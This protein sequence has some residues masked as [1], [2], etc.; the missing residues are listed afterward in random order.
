MNTFAKSILNYFATYTE[1]RFRFQSKSLYKWT[2]NQLTSDFPVFPEFQKKLLD[3][4]KAKKQIDIAVHKSEYTVVLDCDEFKNRLLNKLNGEYDLGYLI[5]CIGESR[6]DFDDTQPS[7]DAQEIK[8]LEGKILHSAF[9]KYNLAYRSAIRD[10]LLELQEEKK[11]ELVHYIKDS[12]IPLTSFNPN[13]I[14]Q[15]I[16]ESFREQASKSKDKETFHAKL[17]EIIK[18]S[19]WNLEMYDLYSMIRK[20]AAMLNK[21]MGTAYIFF[22]E[23]Y[24][25]QNE[26]IEQFPLFLIEIDIEEY[27]ESVHIKS[28][29]GVVLINTPAI[30]SFYFDTILTIPRAARLVEATDYLFGVEKFLQNSYDFYNTFLLEQG[31]DSL[32]AEKRPKIS[33][34]VGFQIVL[35]EDR[36]LLDYSE[37]ITRI[38]AGQG[39][40]FID[41]VKD[42]VSGNVHNTTDEVDK[43]YKERY[44]PK[45]AAA[46]LST[47]PLSLNKTQKRILTALANPKNRIIVIDGPP[48]T[49]KSYTIAAM[50]YWANQNEK[51]VVITS[52]KKAAIDVLDRMMTDYF[53]KL[54][55]RAKPSIMRIS[56]D[57]SQ[58]VNNYQNTLASQV[59]SAS[60]SRVNEFNEDAIE[61]DVGNWREKV[62]D[63]TEQYWGNAKDYPQGIS[64]LLKLE[65]SEQC[66][67][68]KG[69]LTD[70][71]RPVKITDSR[72]SLSDIEKL[73]KQLPDD[74]Q[75]ITIEKLFSLVTNNKDSLDRLLQA[76]NIVNS[77]PLSIPQVNKL[78]KISLSTIVSFSK[79]LSQL[80]LCLKADS[81]IFSASF[82]FKLIARIKYSKKCRE[83]T[84]KIKQLDTLE[85]H[86]LLENI[87][88]INAKDKKDLL[89][90]DF[91]NGISI[92][93]EI[94]GAREYIEEFIQLRITLEFENK[95]IRDIFD[96]LKSVNNLIKNMTPAL[97]G[98]LAVFSDIFGGLL[99][100][101]K[102][103]AN[104]L[105]DLKVL[106]DGKDMYKEL[107]EYIHLF[108]KL[109]QIE[110][111]VLPDRQLVE[112]Y[113]EALHKQLENK[114]D[115]RI[116]NLNNHAGD[117]S[118]IETTLRTGK[119]LT[120]NEAEIILSNISCILSEPELI[121]QYFPMEE[122]LIDILI[123][124]E[125]SQVSIAESISLIL[126]AKQVVVLGDE[127]QYGAVGAVNVNSE[128]AAQY[129]REILDSYEKDYHLAIGEVEKQSLVEDASK[130]IDEEDQESE[131]FFKPEE[132]TKE[133]LKT[134]N[135]RT[136]TLSF[137]KALRN[138]STSLDTHFR[139]FPE[140]IDYSNEF[141]YKPSQIPLKVNR[142]R[143]K[144]IK[145]VLRF[146]EVETRGNAG[147]NINLDEIDAIKEDIN[148]LI[149]NGFKGTI[150]II[151]SFRE[152]RE[153]LEEILRKEMSNYH[154][155]KR[156]HKLA[157][158][159]VGA[160]Q[161]EERDI[162]YYSFVE[163]KKIGNGSLRNIYPVPGGTADNIRK[164]R[165]QRLNVGFS[166]AK[167][168]MVFVHSMP[169]EDYSDTRLGD[170]LKYY[171][172][173]RES[174]IDNYIEN[175]QIFGSDAE[176]E[177]YRL[178]INTEFY[179]KNRGKIR[180][181]AQ[182]PIGK[183]ILES[184]NRYIPKYRVD[185]LLTVSEKG[186]EQSLILEYD[187]IEYHMKSPEIIT[188]SS[189][190]QEYLDYDIERQ[191]ELESYG[192]RFL[193]ITKFT[194]LPKEKGQTKIEVLNGLLEEKFK[195]SR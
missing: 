169:I 123:I 93:K 133:W 82:K 130:E 175:E 58:G 79:L 160:V 14:E 145:E 13:L 190:S 140:I 37:L 73:V 176:K 19:P 75:D 38:D 18:N 183:Y 11:K 143:T 10:V 150:G 129:F 91:L 146:I 90:S 194:L 72:F 67:V 56:R 185:F 148:G 136:S 25:T 26:E 60:T 50:T 53:R 144:P 15:T 195:V 30:N 16:Y 125:A 48:G 115:K 80:S 127:L 5:S 165:M 71:N 46:L 193:R 81:G 63:Q 21:T 191:L 65:Q 156:D 126:R 110:N 88:R 86:D 138:Y 106:F 42:Y 49:G 52:H 155:L 189:S 6:K 59:I 7:C 83:L 132:G 97:L 112:Y 152:Q 78:H 167:D 96:F 162:V 114:N 174:A 55:P 137:S 31:F 119:R 17:E 33:F 45:T 149:S 128:Y 47:I 179:R 173:L 89:L 121:S 164:L 159:F 142:I 29:R 105:N 118:R 178:L 35:K 20:F 100:Q 163:D 9:R 62:T 57:E 94:E 64:E 113:Y 2:N 188:A 27:P 108:V 77:L 181:I 70:E 131:P 39:G 24:T 54:H 168:T 170:A 76:C 154:I 68:R 74:I 51:S 187:G 61:K 104:D 1:T 180:I 12:A 22:H 161:G 171:K 44:P 103:N 111:M 177:L 141:F 23:I 28:E 4:I 98:N 120:K 158:W 124:D 153:Q 43:E 3:T 99:I 8:A 157:I 66:L 36:K 92:N 32:V 182:F 184:F 122:D 134:F 139:S 116:K 102:L 117:I 107:L 87:A 109:S 95:E 101:A 84:D 85:Y 172:S 186:K 135:I 151:S 192:Y 166:R 69:I 34:R 40:K 147:N 41:F